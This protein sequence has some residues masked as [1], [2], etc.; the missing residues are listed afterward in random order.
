MTETIMRGTKIRIYPNKLQ[1]ER[2]DLW[3][4]RTISLWNLLLS[5]E[6]AAYSGENIRP[7][8]RWR[9]IWADVVNQSYRNARH[10]WEH[11]KYTKQGKE[12]KAART[13][14]EP[15]PPAEELL[16]KIL[17]RHGGEEPPKLLIWEHELQKL[18]ARLKQVGHTKWIADLPSHAAQAVTK[19]LIRALQAMLRERKK[20]LSGVGGRNTGFPKFKKSRYAAG[21]VYLA[22]TQFRFDFEKEA[23]M[24][25]NGVGRVRYEAGTVPERGK[26]MGGRL[27]REGEDWY[28]SCQWE[29][30]RPAPLPP[31]GNIAGV[32]IAAKVLV[33]TFD[34]KYGESLFLT[35]EI[36]ERL[37]RRHKL[38]GRKLARRMAAQKRKEKALSARGKNINGGRV[39]TRRSRGF[40]RASERL[41][42]LEAARRNRR[43][44]HLH[45]L[46]TG[47]VQ[48]YDALQVQ[49]M[50]VARLMKKGNVKRLKRH[51]NNAAKPSMRSLK[52][53]RQML[54][55]AAMARTRQMLAYKAADYG[56]DYQETDQLFPDVQRCFACH[57]GNP[58]FKDGRRVTR[59]IHCGERLVRNINA[60]MNEF[61][62]LE[63]R[64]DE[65]KD[66]A[67]KQLVM[68]GADAP[69]K[70]YGRGGMGSTKHGKGGH[71]GKSP[72][73]RHA[74][75]REAESQVV[76]D[77]SRIADPSSSVKE[78][79]DKGRK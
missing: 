58:Q 61:E 68:A 51:E 70:Q 5:I 64:L 79:L 38:A 31:T 74:M 59:C 6:G 29:V 33:T 1:T 49:K 65:A 35:P 18:M 50:D 14:T 22:N 24:L 9:Q 71:S 4:R 28:L 27:W 2:M 48:R 53:V 17:L 36:D 16:D 72:K 11:G 57:G 60:A 21:S 42:A 77:R 13:G 8:L 63:D 43:D 73:L 52:P 34:D 25:P 69:N 45:K 75:K 39:R 26:L 19:D 23:V 78:L 62:V 30:E 32:K 54:R 41:A 55:N 44:D 20:R 37:V 67:A 3:R 40:F 56:R 15:Q 47:I 12:K 76:K 66:A 7:E 10:I 46:T